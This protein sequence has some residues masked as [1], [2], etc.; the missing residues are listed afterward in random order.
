MLLCETYNYTTLECGIMYSDRDNISCLS[1]E[2]STINLYHNFIITI[3]LKLNI[4][5]PEKLMI[6]LIQE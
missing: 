6:L 5:K 3:A 2:R 1:F 4:F